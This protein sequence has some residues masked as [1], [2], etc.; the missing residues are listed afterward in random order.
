MNPSSKRSAPKLAVYSHVVLLTDGK[1]AAPTVEQLV[2]ET[3]K[4]YKDRLEVGTDL[5]TITIGPTIEV[6]RPAVK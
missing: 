4:T 6:A 1:V 5:M 2:A 3:R